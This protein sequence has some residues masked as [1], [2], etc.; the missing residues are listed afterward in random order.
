M[1]DEYEIAATLIDGSLDE[2]YPQKLTERT[3]VRVALP[4]P[5]WESS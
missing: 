5:Q 4:L 2:L 3:M 1:S